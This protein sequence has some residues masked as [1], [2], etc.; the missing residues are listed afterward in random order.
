MYTMKELKD[1]LLLF[2]EIVDAWRTIPRILV[3]CYALMVFILINWYR[4]MSTVEQ[5]E[6]DNDILQT[7]ID[8]GVD[9]VE[10]TELACTVIGVT[11]GPTPEQTAFATAIIGLSTAIFAFYVN[12]GRKWD[13]EALFRKRDEY[14]RYRKTNESGVD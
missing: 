8:S 6:C 3:A 7:L 14:D 13:Q 11:G 1:R 10:A 12:S 2:A 9:P 5:T 4:G